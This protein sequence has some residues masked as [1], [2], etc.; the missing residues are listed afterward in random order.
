M[1][2]ASRL[3]Q[4]EAFTAALRAQQEDQV[5]HLLAQ[6][7]ITD[8][9]RQA[10]LAQQADLAR[11][12]AMQRALAQ[13]AHLAQQADLARITAMQ[14]AQQADQA[15]RLQA[16]RRMQAIRNRIENNKP[17]P[18]DGRKYTQEILDGRLQF[19]PHNLGPRKECEHCGA[20]LWKHEEKLTTIC[21]CK[22]KVRLPLCPAVHLMP[23][24][25]A[26][27]IKMMF[28][29]EG[30][31]GKNLRKNARS[32]NNALTMS[33]LAVNTVIPIH[34]WSPEIMSLIL[35]NSDFSHP[36]HQRTEFPG[37]SGFAPTVIMQG[38][39]YT[40]IGSL[41][42]NENVEPLFLQVAVMDP[43]Y[44]IDALRA[45]MTREI[46]PPTPHAHSE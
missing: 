10:H 17:L 40:S 20:W 1:L 25:P 30:E 5:H 33:S 11:I 13:Q 46:L 26:K 32:L 8:L 22:H 31:D 16:Q 12:T 4:E 2:Q 7:R 18:L 38:K 15:Q 28:S 9:A 27:E 24:G 36:S 23:E 19:E 37:R 39:V 21:C 3:A 41:L 43:T 35:T 45:V 44:D 6:Q 14:R 34:H 29:D 42:P